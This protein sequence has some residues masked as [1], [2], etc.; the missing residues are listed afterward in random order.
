MSCCSELCAH[1]D[2]HV[3]R[4]V[5]MPLVWK[6]SSTQRGGTPIAA[7]SIWSCSTTLLMWQAHLGE[8]HV[9]VDEDTVHA[10]LVCVEEPH[11]LAQHV[12]RDRRIPRISILVVAGGDT[13]D[14][15]RAGTVGT[16]LAKDFAEKW[17]TTFYSCE[18]E[19]RS[20]CNQIQHQ[21]N[22]T[23]CGLDIMLFVV[24]VPDWVVSCERGWVD[25]QY[26]IMQSRDPDTKRC[27]IET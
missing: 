6:I 19:P 3:K 21:V 5:R 11:V 23:C 2:A 4:D 8:E 18:F 13:H 10:A 26:S 17:T 1:K 25:R 24:R 9:M 12:H 15:Q 16:E 27:K 7:R 14:L 20:A 22:M